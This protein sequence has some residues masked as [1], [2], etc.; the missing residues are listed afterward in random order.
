ME[1]VWPCGLL[2]LASAVGGLLA[3]IGGAAGSLWFLF[4][5]VLFPAINR[6]WWLLQSRTWSVTDDGVAD[7]SSG[8]PMRFDEILNQLTT[9]A[10]HIDLWFLSSS[11]RQLGVQIIA[12]SV[13]VIRR[14]LDQ[15]DQTGLLDHCSVDDMIWV[16]CVRLE[17]DGEFAE[18]TLY[19]RGAI[20]R[21]PLIGNWLFWP[22]C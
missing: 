1:Y 21:G 6:L 16:R 13:E 5:L 10:R 15:H 2:S 22:A 19:R 4:G 11:L 17:A 7:G 3:P 12:A 9:A 14:V 20:S 8:G 18:A